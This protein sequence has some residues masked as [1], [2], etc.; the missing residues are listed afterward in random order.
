MVELESHGGNLQPS[1]VWSICLLSSLGR[2]LL[3]LRGANERPLPPTCGGG[4]HMLYMCDYTASADGP[5]SYTFMTSFPLAFHPATHAHYLFSPFAV[6]CP[7][8]SLTAFKELFCGSIILQASPFSLYSIVKILA[9]TSTL[10]RD[11]TRSSARPPPASADTP[12]RVSSCTIHLH[13]FGL[14]PWAPESTPHRPPLRL[15]YSVTNCWFALCMALTACFS[16]TLCQLSS[17]ASLSFLHFT[18]LFFFFFFSP[19][20]HPWCENHRG[21]CQL[22][23][24]TLR[25]ARHRE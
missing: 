4:Q 19:F 10:F 8:C 7:N 16:Q 3:N 13:P 23:N 2:L 14:Q 20:L 5:L 11:W 25:K 1:H 9:Q 22:V 17:H 18:I 6:L 21:L 24:T 12:P 15:T